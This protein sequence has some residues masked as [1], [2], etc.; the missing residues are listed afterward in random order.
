MITSI[1]DRGPSNRLTCAQFTD[2]TTPVEGVFWTHE[3]IV[4]DALD[5]WN[6]IPFADPISRR[7]DER[8]DIVEMCDIR[9]ECLYDLGQL[10]IRGAIPK[11]SYSGPHGVSDILD[12]SAVFFE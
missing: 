3:L 1:E 10:L 11:E 5:D 9:L 2:R 4:V 7:G 12:V 8:I 6:I